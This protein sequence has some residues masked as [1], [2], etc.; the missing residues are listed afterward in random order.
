M[1]T[2]SVHSV[3][4]CGHFAALVLAAGSFLVAGCGSTGSVSGRVT[5]KGKSLPSGTV[6]LLT[7]ENKIFTSQ[8][9]S[10]GTY[11]VR[12][13]PVGPVKIAVQTP[14]HI[15]VND[16]QM[17]SQPDVPAPPPVPIPP[18]YRDPNASGL[19]LNVTGGSQTHDIEVP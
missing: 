3:R 4:S 10:D 2:V 8:I 7:S 19:T 12:Q 14:P 18:K 11:A 16:P 15:I 5:N 6:T 13:L 17:P 9:A 1:S